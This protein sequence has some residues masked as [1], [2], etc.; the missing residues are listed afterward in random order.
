MRHFL[1]P[2]DLSLQELDSLLALADEIARD[3]PPITASV[4]AKS[5]PLFFMNPAP[6]PG[7]PLNPPC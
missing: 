2:L 6:A 1:T 7:S 3:P 4:Q 5:S